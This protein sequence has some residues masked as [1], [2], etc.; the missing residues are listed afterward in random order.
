MK[1]IST[2]KK[3]QLCSFV[4]VFVIPYTPLLKFDHHGTLCAL[5][6]SIKEPQ[7]TLYAQTHQPP[8][9]ASTTLFNQAQ[10]FYTNGES[11]EKGTFGRAER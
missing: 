2:I 11:T 6:I 10:E 8:F 9:E 5:Q 4:S 1:T 7:L 3:T